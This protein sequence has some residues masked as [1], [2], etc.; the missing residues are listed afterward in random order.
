VAAV[1]ANSLAGYLAVYAQKGLEQ[2]IAETPF[3][4]YVTQNFNQEISAGGI[5]VI[6]RISTTKWST[7]NDLTLGW[8]DT[9]ASSSAVTATLKLRD[10]DIVF[11]E[12]EWATLTPQML[13]NNYFPPM[14]HQLANGIVIDAFSNVSTSSY[15]NVF[16]I[17]TQTSMSVYSNP[18][19]AISCSAAL[20]RAEIPFGNRYLIVTPEVM[21]G[22]AKDVLPT[23]VYG[24]PSVR[25]GSRGLKFADFDYVHQYPRFNGTPPQGGATYTGGANLVG[26]AGHKD[27]LVVA[28]R[29]P[30]EINNGLVQSATATDPS[31]G[32]SLQVRV[33]YDTSLPAWRMAVVS[34]FGTAAGNTKAIIPI[35]STV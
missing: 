7:P 4:D 10:Y 6:T 32:L 15:T 26:L 13:Q 21:L 31:S 22:M 20:T 3:L 29:A 25:E 16:T 24:N 2:Y 5:S 18:Y 12:N 19:S 35:V 28:V 11:N 30:I 33:L 14:I 1:S 27:G 17:P 8:A 23:Y 9:A 34:V